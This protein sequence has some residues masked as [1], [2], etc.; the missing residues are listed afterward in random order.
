VIGIPRGIGCALLA[1]PPPRLPVSIA[2]GLLL[3]RLQLPP[4]LRERVVRLERG[5]LGCERVALGGAL[6]E[7]G[8]EAFQLIRIP[9]RFAHRCPSSVP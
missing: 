9:Y 6:R 8:A 3:I 2:V 7:F 1:H 5:D 4:H